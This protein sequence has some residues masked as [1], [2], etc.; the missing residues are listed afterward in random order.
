MRRRG[1]I[2]GWSTA[3]GNERSN[4]CL[5]L[6]SHRVWNLSSADFSLSLVDTTHTIYYRGHWLRVSM[7][8][9]PQP[10]PAYLKK[11]MLK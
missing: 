10:C 11:K 9:P 4:S 7:L 5:A 8:S 6:V 1:V 3:S 2:Q